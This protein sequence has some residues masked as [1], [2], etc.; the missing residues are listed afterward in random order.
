VKGRVRLLCPAR[1]GTPGT[2]VRRR[3]TRKLDIVVSHG[4]T[5]DLLAAMMCDNN[6]VVVERRIALNK[7]AWKRE[8]I[9]SLSFG[10]ERPQIHARPARG[11]L[12]TLTPAAQPTL[13]QTFH[14]QASRQRTCSQ[15]RLSFQQLNPKL[16]PTLNTNQ[17]TANP[18]DRSSPT[19]IN[20]NKPP[21]HVTFST[22]A[23]AKFHHRCSAKP[24]VGH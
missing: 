20:R 18:A 23:T 1:R 16:W 12:P 2:T 10:V 14:K 8:W 22:I 24:S 7:R 21:Y 17:P 4:W 6:V 3:V 11:P 13:V 19:P 9:L 15:T 5:V